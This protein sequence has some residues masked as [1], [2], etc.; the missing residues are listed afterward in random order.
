MK[1]DTPTQCSVLVCMPFVWIGTTTG[2]LPQ[3]CKW[4]KILG[5]ARKCK[6]E[7][8]PGPNLIE[9]LRNRP[10]KVRKLRLLFYKVCLIST[11]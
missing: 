5:R 7:P 10:E 4:G 9:V 11:A 1:V 6:P 3:G 8:G 2:R